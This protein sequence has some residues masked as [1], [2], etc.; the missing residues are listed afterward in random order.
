M[1]EAS[2]HFPRGFLWGT[3]TAAHQVEGAN[4]NNNWARWESEPAASSMI[5]KPAWR[6]I[7]WGGAVGR[8]T[9]AARARQRAERAPSLH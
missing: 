5:R 7:W 6:V 4:A 1:P 9:C 3:A 2:F 8:R